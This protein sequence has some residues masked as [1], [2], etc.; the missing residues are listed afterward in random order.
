MEGLNWFFGIHEKV[1]E[2]IIFCIVEYECHGSWEEN[3]MGFVIASP[4]SRSSTTARR[5]CFMYSE[6]D[7]GLQVYS[8]RENCDRNVS[9]SLEGVWAFNLTNDG[10][11]RK[12]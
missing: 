8:S 12:I 3:G 9:P 1:R 6:T 5:Y 11:I 4:M 10:E 2:N 7:S